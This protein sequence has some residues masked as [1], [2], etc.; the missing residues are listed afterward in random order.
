LNRSESVK[1]PGTYW[2]WG[3]FLNRTPKAEALRPTIDKRDLM[4]LKSFCKAKDTVNRTNRQLTDWEINISTN[5]TI[6]R[7]L[8]SKIYKELKK[9]TS[10]NIK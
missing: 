5:P 6:Y 1:K 4:K 10:K 7:W 3:Y 2:Q 9:L 8:V